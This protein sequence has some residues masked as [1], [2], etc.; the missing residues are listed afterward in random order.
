MA[1]K[2]Y[3]VCARCPKVVCFPML[4]A[5]EEPPINEAPAFCP[6]KLIPEVNPCPQGEFIYR[7]SACCRQNP[8]FM[9]NCH[10]FFPENLILKSLSHT[11]C[12][13]QTPYCVICLFAD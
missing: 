8:L 1:K 2:L 3:P 12:V 5:N 9:G 6:M 7:L 11:I 4:K 10:C 13:G